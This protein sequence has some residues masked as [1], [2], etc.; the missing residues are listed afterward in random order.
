[1]VISRS[2]VLQHFLIILRLKLKKRLHASRRRVDPLE[3]GNRVGWSPSFPHP[4]VWSDIYIYI[5]IYIYIW[6]YLIKV[7][8]R[9]VGE[10]LRHNEKANNLIVWGEITLLCLS[11]IFMHMEALF[12]S[13]WRLSENRNISLFNS[14]IHVVYYRVHKGLSK[15]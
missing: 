15:L 12:K 7:G 1:M 11:L 3:L 6:S 4:R 10:P 8:I 14:N 13:L 5:Y 9:F 2:G